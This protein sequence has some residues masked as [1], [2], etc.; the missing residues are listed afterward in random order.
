M[1]DKFL[2]PAFL[3]QAFQIVAAGLRVKESAEF[4]DLQGHT[5][6]LVEKVNA[7]RTGLPKKADGTEFT[8][9]EIAEIADRADDG[10][11]ETLLRERGYV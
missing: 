4:A 1:N 2:T 3:L 5:A 7:L 11:V 6:E 8:D 9:A 10:F